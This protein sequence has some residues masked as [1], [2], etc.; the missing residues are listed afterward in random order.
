MSNISLGFCLFSV[1][2]HLK[3]LLNAKRDEI[4]RKNEDAS[5]A[6][7]STLLQST[8]QPLEQEVARGVYAK[9]GGHSLFLQRVEQLK[10]QYRQQ[11]G[12]GTQ[13]SSIPRTFEVMC[14]VPACEFLFCCL[15]MRLVQMLRQR[16]CASATAVDKS[17]PSL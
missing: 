7:C 16:A 17:N 4:C 10:A 1:F 6:L 2:V 9:P 15:N 8:F 14:S 3:S 11:P 12:K 5:A 13:V